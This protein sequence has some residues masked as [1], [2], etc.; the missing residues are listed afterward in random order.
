MAYNRG[1][2]KCEVREEKAVAKE[3]CKIGVI[4]ETKFRR[5]I[6]K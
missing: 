4:K 3:L 2:P 6:G 5:P 1:P